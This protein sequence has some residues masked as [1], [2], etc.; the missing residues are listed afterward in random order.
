MTAPRL[1][2]WTLFLPLLAACLP[3]PDAWRQPTAGGA[4]R[5]AVHDGP[6]VLVTVPGLRADVLG[7]SA[8]SSESDTPRLD[9]LAAE[10]E[11]ATTAIVPSTSPPA[12]MASLAFGVDPWHHQ[13]P[14]HLAPAA[15]PYLRPLGEALRSAGF[16]TFLRH[17]RPGRAA[18]SER[19]A[20]LEATSRFDDDR[21]LAALAAT[22]SDARRFVWVH[23]R[24]L[25]PPWTDDGPALAELFPYADPGV[26]LPAALEAE[27]R[28]HYRMA[29]RRV[30]AEIGRLLDALASSPAAGRVALVVTAPHG[31]ELGEQGQVYFAQ[32]LGRAALEV[33]L[34][35]DLPDGWD[36]ASTSAALA[37]R[38]PPSL[39]RL[40]PTL[41]ELAGIA[42]GPVHLPSLF[43]RHDGPVVA[44]LYL[45]NGTNRFSG[46]FRRDEGLVQVRV[47]SRFSPPEREYYLAQTR[48]AGRDPLGMEETPRRI[49][50]RLKKAFLDAPPWGREVEMRLERWESSGETTEVDDPALAAELAAE[51]RREWLRWKGEA[52][53]AGEMRRELTRFSEIAEAPQ[54]APGE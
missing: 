9:R 17:P 28:R 48:Q 49:F 54:A 11:L 12:S 7:A 46:L 53:P 35:V 37:D 32:N 38:P 27:A 41:L 21:F 5:P 29:L 51:T 19:F 14:S 34:L 15:N 45:A 26:P 16:E 8:A 52:G 31:L 50:R 1:A 47:E 2:A 22:R 42:P 30:D 36:G 4:A 24:G 39:L 43:R 20:G 3:P 23:L 18:A 44:S 6:I 33:P 13:L 10:S 40:H 25:E